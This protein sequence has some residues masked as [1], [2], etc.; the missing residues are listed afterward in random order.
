MGPFRESSSRWTKGVGEGQGRRRTRVAGGKQEGER[1][2]NPAMANGMEAG[3]PEREDPTTSPCSFC[4]PRALRGER[5]SCSCSSSTTS[6]ACTSNDSS[7]GEK[8][9]TRSTP[10][11]PSHRSSPRRVLF[12]SFSFLFL[13]LALPFPSPLSRSSCRCYCSCYASTPPA[14]H[15]D[16]RYRVGGTKTR[17]S[18]RERETVDGATILMLVDKIIR[19]SFVRDASSSFPRRPG[20]RDASPVHA[21]SLVPSNY[22]PAERNRARSCPRFCSDSGATSSVLIKIIKSRGLARGRRSDGR[23]SRKEK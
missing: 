20:R 19:V 6:D 9:A 17:G 13:H 22:R 11:A 16:H 8:P 10:R 1:E 2:K 5:V 21:S 23:A 4:L 18:E 3:N 7:D 15:R 12:P 14:G